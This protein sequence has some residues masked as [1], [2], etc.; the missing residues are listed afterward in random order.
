MQERIPSEIPARVRGK[1]SQEKAEIIGGVAAGAVTFIGVYEYL[2]VTGQLSVT[3]GIGVVG[4]AA[5]ASAVSESLVHN[6][7]RAIRAPGRI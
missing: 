1:I 3:A 4:L 6:A 5:G 7:K 2:A